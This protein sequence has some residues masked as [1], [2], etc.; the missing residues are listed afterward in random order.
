MVV[1]GGLLGG[2]TACALAAAGRSVTV[3]SRSFAGWLRSRRSQGLKIEL[4]EGTV[5]PE[6][7]LMTLL[8]DADAV[9]CFVGYSTPAR[10]AASSLTSL[11]EWLL[12]VLSVLEAAA[13]CGVR[14]AIVAS[15]GG[16]IYGY[17]RTLPTPESD[18]LAPI[19]AHGSTSIAIEAY[20]EL[21][22]RTE[23][24][25]TVVLRYANVYGP[26]ERDRGEQ[27]VVAAWCGALALGEPLTLIGAP[28]TRR[29]FLY[30]SDAASAAVA[31]LD[32]CKPGV[33]NVGSGAA[34]PLREVLEILAEVSGRTPEVERRQARG[35]DVSTN[36]LDAGLFRACSGWV[37]STSLHEG[38]EATWRWFSSAPAAMRSG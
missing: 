13:R 1:G 11:T 38:I 36:E 25:E 16:T 14:R 31:A 35:V 8:A 32:A 23:Q 33:Y 34:T 6:D 18:P 19:S 30:A 15:S 22:R 5:P 2:H 12:P 3:L 26:G 37:P 10:S 20:A 29:D 4:I 17:A 9:C 7:Q 28:E 27:G 21:Y 24:L